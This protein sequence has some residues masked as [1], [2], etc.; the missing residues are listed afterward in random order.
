MQKTR[1]ATLAFGLCLF[2]L[3]WGYAPAAHAAADTPDA[4]FSRNLPALFEGAGLAYG[5]DP[6]LLSAMARVESDYRLDAVS[7]AG[8]EGLMQLMP[9][10]AARYGV[11][12]A[13]DPVEN[14]L[15]AARF[16]DH[17]RHSDLNGRASLSLPEL[18][19]AYNAGP[20]AVRRFGGLP[21]YR[22]TREYVRRVLWLYLA[23]HVPQSRVGAALRTRRRKPRAATGDLG[24][25]AILDK[26]N[27][28]RHERER[29]LSEAG[30]NE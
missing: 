26:L 11:P 29:L 30:G 1:T 24:D 27:R 21:P 20:A 15:G 16:L 8:A 9:A 6:S 7:S 19:A 17:L 13:F 4:S 18:L 10:T 14:V 3:Q 22:E 5:I 25:M 23:G 28:L 2:V 12:D